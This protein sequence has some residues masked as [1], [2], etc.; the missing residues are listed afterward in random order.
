[1]ATITE[2]DTTPVYTYET[3]VADNVIGSGEEVARTG[4]PPLCRDYADHQIVTQRWGHYRCHEYEEIVETEHTWKFYLGVSLAIVGGVA[5]VATGVGAAAGATL[6][7]TASGSLTATGGV[8]LAGSTLTAG[9]GVAV[10]TKTDDVTTK[11]KGALIRSFEDDKKINGT[12]SKTNRVYTS[13][14]H[15][16]SSGGDF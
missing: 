12:S 15:P 3:S 8:I 9:T 11:K 6:I 13:G 16:C 5:L 10:A 7:V 4:N 2:C 1:V 14:W